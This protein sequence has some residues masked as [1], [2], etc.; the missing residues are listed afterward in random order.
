MIEI[1]NTEV[2]GWEHA[3]RG[4]RKGVRK[5]QSGNY[6][7]YVPLNGKMINLGTYSNEK[8]ARKVVADWK[9]NRF[10]ECVQTLNVNPND[11]V[12]VHNNYV[13]FPSGIIVN[14]RGKEMIG[15]IDR[16]GY[17][18][19]ILNGKQYRVH[20]VIATAFV[21]N[22]DDKSCVNHID[23][24]KTNNNVN[25]LEWVTHSENTLHSFANGLQDNVS[26]IPIYTKA[27]K[28]YIRE[29]CREPY[30]VVALALK[31]N[32]ETVRKY[33]Q[34]ARRGIL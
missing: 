22:P 29:H 25:N 3:I 31:R 26:G 6:E 11:G 30:K 17:R 20:R 24:N 7:A 9:I 4:M 2:V 27:E 5:S 10:I 1:T 21:P 12:L 16:C 18:E 19:V 8:T 23:G 28:D 15:H 14:L 33:M 34:K 32:P 13:A